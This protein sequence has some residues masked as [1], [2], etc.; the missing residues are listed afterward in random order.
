MVKQ[1]VVHYFRAG[2]NGA[3]IG[4]GS[5]CRAAYLGAQWL[6][7]L[8]ISSAGLPLNWCLGTS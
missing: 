4:S 5:F 1:Q 7:F 2:C 3:V 8:S 6:L